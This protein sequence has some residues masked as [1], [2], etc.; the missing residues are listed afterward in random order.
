MYS[1]A[2][3]DSGNLEDLKM[4][5]GSKYEGVISQTMT[6]EG[7]T[8][9]SGR[10]KVDIKWKVALRVE[11]LQKVTFKDQT[12]IA[13]KIKMGR[14]KIN[15]NRKTDTYEALYIP[16]LHTYYSWKMDNADIDRPLSCQLVDM[17]PLEKASAPDANKKSDSKN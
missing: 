5:V 6:M 17:E 1:I 13:Y 3:L 4:V 8:K 12:H 11:S 14:T 15:M 7:K 2:K 16:K 10:S 9:D